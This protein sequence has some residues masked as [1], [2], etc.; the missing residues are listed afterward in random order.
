VNIFR[1]VLPLNKVILYLGVMLTTFR[2]SYPQQKD[3]TIIVKDEIIVTAGKVPVTVS[4][5]P[6]SVFILRQQDILD[7]PVQDLQS[8][9]SYVPGLDV[10]AR[11]IKGVQADV[12]I[13]G[14]SFEQTLILLD[15]VKL[16]DPQT[17]HHNM[18]L[19]VNINDIER[20]EVLKGQASSIYGPNAIGGVINFITKKDSKSE[21]S[22]DLSD[23]G[24][25]FYNGGLSLHAPVLESQNMFSI[26]KSKS[27][28]YRHN[29]DFDIT[30]YYFKSTLPFTSGSANV[31]VG[32]IDKSFGAN[33]FYTTQFP[34][35]WE[36]TKTL[37]ISSSA[38]YS[39][40]QLKLSPQ[41]FWRNNKDYYLLDYTNPVFYM[42]N[43][44]SNSYGAGLQS[45]YQTDL[46][47]VEIGGDLNFDNINSSNLGIHNRREGGVSAE[48]AS[49]PF[50]NIKIMLNGFA[51]NY[52][53][54]GWKFV[55]GIN[56][57][58]QVSNSLNFYSTF[59]KSFRIPTYTELYYNS[60]AQKGNAFLQ[61]E[62]AITYE[63]GFNY[64]ASPLSG[65]LSL[66]SRNG[67][68]LIDWVKG[69]ND[70]YWLSRNIAELN[71]IGI[72]AGIS[73]R[74]P[75]SNDFFLK[76]ISLNYTYLSS[77]FNEPLLLSQYILDHL[78]HQVIA[79]ISHTIPYSFIFNW[80]FRYENRYN[81]ESYFIADLKL[82]RSFNNLEISFSALN[83][84]NKSYMDLTGIPLP[85]RWLQAGFSFKLTN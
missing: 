62:E 84:F 49:A 63:L 2:F 22:V 34:N 77:D 46:G 50:E 60:P 56:L 20:I 8:L 81:F 5:T 85:G 83:L 45:I 38:D 9:L 14:S 15:G 36:Q 67:K 78:R 40:G 25:G 57:V 17:G 64:N 66:F 23:G 21:L 69:I 43:H 32:Y 35:Q 54:Y 24:F 42:N 76:K 65:N 53:S 59:G 11:G 73:Y 51:Y 82:S 68:N 28:G 70:P 37:L 19:P 52:D 79:E 41:I 55:P 71:T 74:P 44:N 30:T 58:Y 80:A 75:Y 27:D 39:I 7:S 6:R 29:T 4:E 13:R 12:S 1:N 61:P 72:D 16:M 10:R 33:G 3:T 31:S 47:T 48:F 18:N 26:S